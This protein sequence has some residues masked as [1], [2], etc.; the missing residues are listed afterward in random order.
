MD[1]TVRLCMLLAGLAAVAADA[2]PLSQAPPYQGVYQPQGVDEI[3]IWREDDE[4]ERKLASSALVIRDE[5]LTQYLKSVLCD[6]VGADRCNS[7]RIYV[8]REPSFNATMSPNGTMRIFSGLFLRVQSEAELGAVLGHEFGHFEM[9]HS[10]GKFKSARSGSD[11]LAWSAVL[12]SMSPSYD[13]RRT[14]QNLELSVYGNLFRYGRDQEREADLLGVGYLNGSALRPQAA[15]AVW[16]NIMGELESSANVRGLRKPNFHSIAFTASHPPSGERAAYLSELAAANGDGRA[17]GASRYRAALAPWLPIFLEDQIKLNDFGASEFIIANLAREGWTAG[18][19]L[20]RGELYRTRGHQRDLVS[21]AEFYE[22]ALEQDGNLSPAYRGLGLSLMKLGR[23]D[24]AI[25]PL[26][27]Y[28]EL[29]P[30]ASD[31]KMIKLMV[32]EGT[33]P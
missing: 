1:M 12:A 19:W 20:A 23:R 9:R 14:Y 11:L 27:K 29:S 33:P 30:A 3:G 31:A 28:L 22:K 21:A 4:S 7:V 13:A 18:L 25:G 24:E 2:K 26:R 10:L 15:A 5:A 32:P 6:T 17:D 16:E 8:M